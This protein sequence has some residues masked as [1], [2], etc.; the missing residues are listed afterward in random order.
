MPTCLNVTEIVTIENWLSASQSRQQEIADGILHGLPERF[1]AAE[2]FETKTL[3]KGQR[4]Q[5]PCFYDE[6][7]DTP[8]LLIPG[9]DC[10]YGFSTESTKTVKQLASKSEWAMLR[11]L[12]EQQAAATTVHVQPFL[13][14]RFPLFDW[15]A[16]ENIQLSDEEERPDFGDDD[17]P[18]PS[19]LSLAES[20]EFL[21]VSGYR[22]LVDTEW[23]YLAKGN[24][25]HVFLTGQNMPTEKELAEACLTTFGSARKNKSSANPFGLS[26][27]ALAT[28]TTAVEGTKTAINNALV[29]GGAA[30]FYPFQGPGQ[31]AMLLSSLRMGLTNMPGQV[32]GLRLAMDIPTV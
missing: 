25:D 10:Q 21:G 9:G 20:N 1:C 2:P 6:K 13:A 27:L 31:W 30:G 23:E 19:Y 3:I 11:G 32:A 26:G 8:L 7:F 22:L 29:R 5:L 28:L 15:V 14:S 16:E 4:V 17:G 24:G 12:I 18:H